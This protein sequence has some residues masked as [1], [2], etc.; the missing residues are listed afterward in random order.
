VLLYFDLVRRV[1]VNRLIR[2]ATRG[3]TNR[4]A[5]SPRI[6]HPVPLVVIG[7]TGGEGFGGVDWLGCA[8]G[9]SLGEGLGEFDDGDVGASFGGDGGGSQA[10]GFVGY[11]CVV[12]GGYLEGDD[13]GGVQGRGFV[14]G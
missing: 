10:V 2:T 4:P 3:N 11:Y 12:G 13:G 7:F 1:V 6:S 9:V 8:E 14:G 5:R